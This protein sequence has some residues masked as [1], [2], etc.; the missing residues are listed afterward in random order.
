MRF[1]DWI[2]ERM[3]HPKEIPPVRQFLREAFDAGAESEARGD[4]DYIT[5]GDLKQWLLDYPEAA[6][7]LDTQIEKFS[8]GDRK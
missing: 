6:A 7:H 2:A 1:D 4:D 8:A 3:K 5:I